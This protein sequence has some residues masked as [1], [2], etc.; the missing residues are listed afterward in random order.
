MFSKSESTNWNLA[1]WKTRIPLVRQW[2]TI[3]RI[4]K[5]RSCILVRWTQ[6]FTRNRQ[7]LREYNTWRIITLSF[8]LSNIFHYILI[9]IKWFHYVRYCSKFHISEK[10]LFSML[11]KRFIIMLTRVQNILKIA[12]RKWNIIRMKSNNSF[13]I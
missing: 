1:K 3:G 5:C 9:H 2:Q 12:R 6:I 13:Y 10:C 7:L 8:F 4:L 11:V